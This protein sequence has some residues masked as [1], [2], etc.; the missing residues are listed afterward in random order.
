MIQSLRRIGTLA[1]CGIVMSL[2]TCAFGQT[3][4]VSQT[5]GGHLFNPTATFTQVGGNIEIVLA[6]AGGVASANA[7][8]LT[9]LFWQ[10]TNSGAYGKVSASPFGGSTVENDDGSAYAQGDTLAQHN[11][12]SPVSFGIFNQGIG[13]AGFGI[14]GDTDAFAGGGSSPILDGVD[15]GLVNGFDAGGIGG[16]SNPFV[17]NQA[18]Y[19]LSGTLGNVTN[20]RFQYGSATTEQSFNATVVPEGSSLILLAG[21]VVPL[22]GSVFFSRR[23]KTQ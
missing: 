7:Q 17:V 2:A 5:V 19:V 16:N 12:Y 22:V 1:W 11:A 20:V 10:D 13:A 14:F 4:S 18:K 8:V 6:E 3:F 21:G 9:G 23:R 15:W